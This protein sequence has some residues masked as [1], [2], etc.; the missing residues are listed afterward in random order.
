[1]DPRKKFWLFKQSQHFCA[2]PW[3]HFEVWSTGDIKT[4][5]KGSSFGN[6]NETSIEDILNNNKIKSI[7][8]DLLADK[9][10]KNCIIVEQ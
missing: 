9:L 5:S 6:I 10:N 7:K 3:N 4:C 1:M 8:D 2:V